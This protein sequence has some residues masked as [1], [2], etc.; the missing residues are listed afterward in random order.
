[1]KRRL[2]LDLLIMVLIP[3]FVGLV[4]AILTTWSVFQLQKREGTYVTTTGTVTSLKRSRRFGDPSKAAHVTFT[5]QQGRPCTFLTK[6]S[7]NPSR[8]AVGQAVAVL[9][10]PTSRRAD[11]DASIDSFSEGWLNPVS[12]GLAA[13]A[14]LVSGVGLLIVAW[15]RLTQPPRQRKH[16][17]T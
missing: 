5:D 17:M 4:F 15:P 2:E 3:I 10:D 14:F 6:S 9:Y 8:Y 16:R 7:S 13:G 12:T 1:M 11:L